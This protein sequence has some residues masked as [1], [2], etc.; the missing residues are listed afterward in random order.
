MVVLNT[1]FEKK[2]NRLITYQ[3]GED[4]TQI[5]YILISRENRKLVRDVKVISGEEIAPQHRLVIGDLCLESPRVTKKTFVPRRKTWK[6]KNGHTA[7]VFQTQF[8]KAVEGVKEG[9]TVEGKW[10]RL[11][12]NLLCAA[13]ETCG[14]TKG[15]SKR[16]ETWW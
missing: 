9:Q 5:D 16:C 4:S 13:D 14:W 1:M 6:L 7:S 12:D 8:S 2:D 15:P 11:K 3:S 10:A